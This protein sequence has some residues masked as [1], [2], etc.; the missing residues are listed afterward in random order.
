MLH[1]ILVI[2]DDI[3]CDS[4]SERPVSDELET[5]LEQQSYNAFNMGKEWS[6]ATE[7][8]KY[9]RANAIVREFLNLDENYKV[10]FITVKSDE[11]ENTLVAKDDRIYI[12]KTDFTDVKEIKKQIDLYTGITSCETRKVDSEVINNLS[13]LLTGRYSPLRKDN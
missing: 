9:K 8:I 5:L 1:D 7:D 13:K 2:I 12:F 10:I 11:L 6:D 3:Q 4:I